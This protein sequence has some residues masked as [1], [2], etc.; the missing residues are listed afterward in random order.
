M[1]IER[2]KNEYIADFERLQQQEF[3][4]IIYLLLLDFSLT[5]ILLKKNFYLHLIT[6]EL[7]H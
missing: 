4:T 6:L 3:F 7:N 1:L 2:E 5:N